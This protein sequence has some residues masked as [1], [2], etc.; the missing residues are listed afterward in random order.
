MTRARESIIDLEAT[1]YYH[2]ICRC[3]RRAFLCGEDEFSG[4]S[5]EH[6]R[7][8]IVDRLAFLSSIFAIEVASYAVMSNHYHLVLRV[9]KKKA[10]N[11]SE[12]TVIARW[13]QLCS[14]PEVVVSYRK[15]PNQP[16]V[17]ET[18]Q[19][20]IEKWR[21]RLM[22]I[23][24]LMRFLNEHLA[25]KANEED[26]CKGRFWEGR[27]KSQALLDEAAVITAMSYVDL[28]P[29]RA[30]MANTPEAS[31]YT[32]IQ[33]RINT[34]N[35]KDNQQDN[36]EAVVPLVQL[37]SSHQQPHENSVPFSLADYL[38]LVD[39]AGR[40][41]LQNKRGFIEPEEH[42]VLERL[43]IDHE[44]FLELMQQKDDLSKLSVM[45]STAS[46]TH[47]LERLEKKFVKGLT[48][49]QRIFT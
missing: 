25:R 12:G 22:D 14:I 19:E 48:I 31:D 39:Y 20:I 24:W 35:L 37:S 42:P 29:I 40:V 18:A 33:Q 1:P 11:W 4:K 43:N 38:Q 27:F 17:K 7:Q 2:C 13:K 45:G 16:G 5:F 28:N 21:A 44:G 15:N 34:L 3:V 32:S 46:L 36:S 49:N 30:K 41:I 23:S 47:Y 8:W 10:E 26:D 6:R 9:D